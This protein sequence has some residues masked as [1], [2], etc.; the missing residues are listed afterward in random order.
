MEVPDHLTSNIRRGFIAVVLVFGGASVLLP[1]GWLTIWL[2]N[3]NNLVDTW[4]N[5]V[6]SSKAPPGISDSLPDWVK[7]LITP[8]SVTFGAVSASVGM[9][10]KFASKRIE[11][12]L[13]SPFD[14]QTFK[15]IDRKT[16]FTPWVPLSEGRAGGDGQLVK[17]RAQLRDWA[18][19]DVDEGRLGCVFRKPRI[20]KPFKFWLVSGPNC[21][22]KTQTVLELARELARRAEFGDLPIELTFHERVAARSKRFWLSAC[23][24]LHTAIWPR[25]CR[26]QRVWDA[27]LL[28]TVNNE[29]LKALDAWRPR[30][31]TFIVLDDP[32]LDKS[33][34]VIE[35]LEALSPKF[36]CP[37][38]L[39]IVDRLCPSDI[40]EHQRKAVHTE[41]SEVRMDAN[42][43]CTLAG[44]MKAAGLAESDSLQ[45]LWSPRDRQLAIHLTD[46]NPYL[47]AIVLLRLLDPAISLLALSKDLVA[48]R[49]DEAIG[50]SVREIKLRIAQRLIGERVGE[51]IAGICKKLNMPAHDEKMSG[52]L[53][54]L[55]CATLT[56]GISAEK[57]KK[58]AAGVDFNV[59]LLQKIQGHIEKKDG[60]ARLLA[61]RPRWV[62]VAFIRRVIDEASDSNTAAQE[63]L[64]TGWESDPSATAKSLLV[65]PRSGHEPLLTAID[66]L[67]APNEIDDKASLLGLALL[68]AELAIREP[69]AYL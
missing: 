41:L 69:V 7:P 8:I 1:F 28:A 65:W 63:I 19:A 54:A 37:V 36:F 47:I 68:F 31:P 11:F 32:A 20:N 25:W 15:R 62:G 29:S 21:I 30:R 51:L 64:R 38:R 3:L 18:N 35:K 16:G 45:Q 34:E 2:F 48:G 50:E 57:V 46:G 56:D 52:I 49:V 42:D 40:P 66:A 13:F 43:I 59:P 10:Y 6:A 26:R 44:A 5:A 27:G 58:I 60:H 14:D 22:G 9:A 23:A 39:V 33:K 12:F 4:W 17:L 55:A 24:R 53:R 61:V 67:P